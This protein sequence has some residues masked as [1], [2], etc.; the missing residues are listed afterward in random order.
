MT[1]LVLP[2]LIAA[3]P[4]PTRRP[5]DRPAPSGGNTPAEHQAAPTQESQHTSGDER[6]TKIAPLVVEIDQS[7]GHEAIA[8]K[9]QGEGEWYALPDWWVAGFTG[10]LFIA[11]A[12]L[13]VA[14]FLL[15]RSTNKAVVDASKGLK[16]AEET[17]SHSR[18]AS[19]RELRAY[20]CATDIEVSDFQIGQRPEFKFFPRNY[21][22]T[23]AKDVQC[24]FVIRGCAGDPE[25]FKTS[26]VGQNWGS[27]FVL[28]PSQDAPMNARVNLPLNAG[29]M[30]D[31]V[32]KKVTFVAF[33][34]IRYRDIFGKRHWTI[35]RNFVMPE[36]L[37]NGRGKIAAS[38]KHNRAN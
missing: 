23:P 2:L 1:V 12:G 32:A 10:A 7:E 14:T 36:N 35:F 6:G 37:V 27:K 20:I 21:G 4:L 8:T 22:V 16:I 31:F 9:S 13:W 25:V 26:L 28:G 33:G 30:A 15:W 5:L 38:G 3:A 11:T 17:L 19:H 34:L 29:D 24:V 18:E